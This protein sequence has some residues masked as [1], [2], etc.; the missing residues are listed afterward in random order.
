MLSKIKYVED[1]GSSTVVEPPL[2][3][4]VHTE[5]LKLNI[6]EDI[7]EGI[8]EETEEEIAEIKEDVKEIVNEVKEEITEI[9]EDVENIL[10]ELKTVQDE[11][12]NEEIVVEIKPKGCC[13]LQ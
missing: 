6:V 7:E 11:V 3:S 4:R 13:V 2:T 9:K 8:I 12:K 5:K 10:E 1:D